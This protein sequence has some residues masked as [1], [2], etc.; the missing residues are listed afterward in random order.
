MRRTPM[1][2]GMFLGATLL[3]TAGCAN[4]QSPHAAAWKV[5]SV[6][7]VS[8]GG[9][10]SEA[11][12]SLGR[13]HDRARAWALAVESYRKSVTAD[14]QNVEA[15]NALGVALSRAGRHDEAVASLRAALALDPGRGHLHSNLGNALLR[16]G[17]PQEATLELKQAVLHDAADG[18][19]LANLRLALGQTDPLAFAARDPAGDPASQSPTSLTERAPVGLAAAASGERFTAPA[20]GH[21]VATTPVAAGP[22]SFISVS[23]PV[24]MQVVDRPTVPSLE[25]PATAS[26]DNLQVLP[27]ASLRLA[28]TGVAPSP[29]TFEPQPTTFAARS[30]PRIEIANGNGVVGM[31]A[32]L[33]AFLRG[34]GLVQ[35]ALLSN[36]RPFN[37]TATVVHYRV[38]FRDAAARIVASAPYR[39]E[40]AEAPG[41]IGNAD[42]R[43]VLGRDVRDD[44]PCPGICIG[45]PKAS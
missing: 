32:R 10:I 7:N 40:L 19:A 36:L 45:T 37:T 8:N 44:D 31:A 14:P 25:A 2:R 35:Q 34:N 29:A 9:R 21:H 26:F 1:L 33:G 43:V 4:Q 20:P 15:H 22:P 39:M 11:H 38:G 41:G 6:F 16:A 13:Q 3:A 18:I 27:Q 24:A 42:I 17:R 5:E 23:V 30:A 12:Y 28:A